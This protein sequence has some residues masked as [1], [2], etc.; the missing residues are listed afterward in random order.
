MVNAVT[1]VDEE[2][3]VCLCCVCRGQIVGIAVRLRFLVGR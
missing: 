3:I 1:V 2:Q